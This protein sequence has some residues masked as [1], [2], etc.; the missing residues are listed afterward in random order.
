MY[1]VRKLPTRESKTNPKRNPEFVYRF[2]SDGG[3]K[4]SKPEEDEVIFAGLAEINKDPVNY[5][6]LCYLQRKKIGKEP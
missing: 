1:K 4:V 6:K 3:S 2:K 5:E